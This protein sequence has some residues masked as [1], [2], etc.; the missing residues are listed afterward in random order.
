MRQ[1]NSVLLGF[2]MDLLEAEDNAR[3]LEEKEGQVFLFEEPNE[4]DDLGKGEGGIV[5]A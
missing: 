2:K 4:T 1:L 5:G 3:A